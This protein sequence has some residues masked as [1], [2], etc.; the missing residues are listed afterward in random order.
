MQTTLSDLTSQLAVLKRPT[1]GDSSE[2]KALMIRANNAERRL[3]NAQNQ[4]AAAEEKMAAMNQKTTA[5]DSKWEAR[6]KEYEARLR[7][8]EE[9]VKRERQGYKER[10]LELENQ[11]KCVVVFSGPPKSFT[12]RK[13]FCLIRLFDFF[14]SSDH[15]RDKGRLRRNGT[16]NWPI[17]RPRCHRKWYHHH[18]SLVTLIPLLAF[19]RRCSNAAFFTLLP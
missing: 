10:V 19:L 17:L 14:G 13:M 15:Y 18:G 5:A 7:A 4:L 3:A 11:I 16:S 2:I 8:A 12:L 6:V 9:K 1:P